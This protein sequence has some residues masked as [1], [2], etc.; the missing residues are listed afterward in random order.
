MNT[1]NSPVNYVDIDNIPIGKWFHTGIVLKEKVIDIYINGFLKKR[2][3]LDGVPKQNFG[4]LWISSFGGFAG[5]ISRMRYYDY[6]VKFSEIENSIRRGPST[7][8][9]TSSMQTPPYLTPYW[10]SNEY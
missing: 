7:K 9:P 4:N 3:V 8:M 10:W 5:Y 6:A 2:F 1:Y